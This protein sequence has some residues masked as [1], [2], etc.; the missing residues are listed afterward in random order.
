MSRTYVIYKIKSL[1]STIDY[2]Y[3]GSTQNFIKRKWNHK[4]RCNTMHKKNDNKLYN[5]IRENGGWIN[6]QMT[7]IEEYLCDTPLQARMREQVLIDEIEKNKLNSINAFISVEDKQDQIAKRK[8]EYEFKKRK[9][10][11]EQ[12]AEQIKDFYFKNKDQMEKQQKEYNLKTLD[13]MKEY[14]FKNREQIAEQQQEF[15]VKS[16]DKIAELQKG[17]RAVNKDKAQRYY[18]WR[19]ISKEF[20]SI[21]LDE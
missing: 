8:K 6:F 7:P 18:T 16:R 21:L 10:I 14:Y 1:D 17:Y 15:Y 12:I 5:T 13:Q 9:Q 20:L 2:C 4:S 11:A 19:K 3:V